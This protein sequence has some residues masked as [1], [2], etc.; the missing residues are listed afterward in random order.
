MS[1]LTETYVLHNGV[2]IPKVGSPSDSNDLCA[3]LISNASVFAS[4]FW[5]F[6][7]FSLLT[8]SLIVI[9]YCWAFL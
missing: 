1:V 4:I 5:V 3:T 7:I 8:V 2:K 6:N 9:E